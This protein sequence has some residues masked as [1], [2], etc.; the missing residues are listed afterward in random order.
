MSDITLTPKRTDITKVKKA[1]VTPP[2][3]IS[4]AIVPIGRVTNK[5]VIAVIPDKEDT[6]SGSANP[7]TRH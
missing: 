6:K 1:T 7:T 5:I 4:L 2:V 3:V